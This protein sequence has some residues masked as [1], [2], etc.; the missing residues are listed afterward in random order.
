MTDKEQIEVL[1]AEIADL[2]RLLDRQGQEI[3]QLQRTV[4]TVQT[5][6]K[7]AGAVGL[8]S[9]LAMIKKQVEL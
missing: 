4:A 8:R 7:S 2:N 9:A 5:L 3:A 1:E 6:V